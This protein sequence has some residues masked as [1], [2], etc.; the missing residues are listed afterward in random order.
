[1]FMDLNYVF[2]ILTSY[3]L[4]T[5]YNTVEKKEEMHFFR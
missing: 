4:W 3:V 5:K 2:N 1:M